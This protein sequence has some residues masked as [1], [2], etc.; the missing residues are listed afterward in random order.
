MWRIVIFPHVLVRRQLAYRTFRVASRALSDFSMMDCH[1]KE[2][3]LKSIGIV[4]LFKCR[5]MNIEISRSGSEELSVTR[6]PGD[7]N[8][9]V[10]YV[11]C[12]LR[13]LWKEHDKE[14]KH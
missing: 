4:R 9:Q 2:V 10:G 1:E 8:C 3:F 11:L 6:K 5:E 13:D 12:A 14:F 7:F